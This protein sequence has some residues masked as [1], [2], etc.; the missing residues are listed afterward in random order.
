MVRRLAALAVLALG[1]FTRPAAAFFPEPGFYWN[2]GESGTGYAIELQ[3]NF[4]FLATYTYLPNGQA[5]FYT[6]G[7][8]LT[9]D[10]TYTGVINQFSGGSCITCTP[11]TPPGTGQNVGTVTI[12][13]DT[14]Q[15]ANITWNGRTFR[16]ERFNFLLGDKTDQ[17]LGEWTI[18][19]DWYNLGTDYQDYPYF[20]E[21]AVF[22]SVDRSGSPAFYDGCRPVN[23]DQRCTATARA[24]HDAS[25]FYN[26]QT[27]EQIFLVTEEVI[28]GNS[29]DEFFAYYSARATTGLNQIEGVFEVCFEGQC[30]AAGA[31][32]LPMRGFRSASRRFVQ[33]GSGPNVAADKVIASP[34][35]ASQHR[36][37]SKLVAEAIQ[38]GGG[39]NAEEVKARYGF[40]PRVSAQ[41]ANLLIARRIAKRSA[42]Q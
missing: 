25:G 32:Y 37:R 28:S 4:L 20:G 24:N 11:F 26:T 2:T 40:D 16:I 30:G 3:D 34:S 8:F 17:M 29:P 27:G 22:D 15:S 38:N 18:L 13:F 36:S 1:V 42:I 39:L 41:T 23:A 9:N 6:S 21:L 5:V 33:T 19:L 31:R 12:V 14:E 7:G 35:Q 10:T